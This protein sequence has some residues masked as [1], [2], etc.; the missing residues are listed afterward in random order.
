MVINEKYRHF[1]NKNFFPLLILDI[2]KYNFVKAIALI[3]FV[4]SVIF[5]ADCLL[6]LFH[7]SNT[8]W[9]PDSTLKTLYFLY[10]LLIF[11]VVYCF[12]WIV[13]DRTGAEGFALAIFTTVLGIIYIFSPIDFVPDPIPII[14]TFDD[15]LLGGLFIAMGIFSW[16][17][18]T[19]KHLKQN[20]LADLIKKGEYEKAL[21]MLIESEGFKKS[22]LT[23]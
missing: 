12:T 4:A 9:R 5:F 2:K 8:W 1:E 6:T 19:K 17:K 14:G 22:K 13:F 11:T 15:W 21:I 16:K 10:H 3:V 18:A 7:W 20:Y 23:N